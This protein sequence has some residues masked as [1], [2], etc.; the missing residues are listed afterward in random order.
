MNSHHLNT[1]NFA[2]DTNYTC[3]SAALDLT[4]LYCSRVN[5][6]GVS[7]S[8]IE[9]INGA[10]TGLY[11]TGDNYTYEPL[12]VDVLID[13]DFEVFFELLK[14]FRINVNNNNGTFADIEF[15]FFINVSNSKG[16]HLFKATMVNARLNSMGSVVL[17]S[18][19][20]NTELVLPLSF[21]FDY[22]EFEHGAVN[23]PPIVRHD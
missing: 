21:D 22:V 15:D 16:K 10:G 23:V 11:S 13:E 12:S 5:I 4:S 18:T 2:Q 19:S 8:H 6:P 3:G 7:L 17:D 9:L 20:E 14:K 1:N